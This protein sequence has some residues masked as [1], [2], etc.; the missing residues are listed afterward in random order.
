MGSF[1]R[2]EIPMASKVHQSQI[3]ANVSSI[4]DEVRK[5]KADATAELEAAKRMIEEKLVRTED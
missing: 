3:V 4:H 5:L 1:V 2:G